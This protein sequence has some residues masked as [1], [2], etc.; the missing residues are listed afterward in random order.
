MCCI[1]K[2]KVSPRPKEE[3]RRDGHRAAAQGTRRQAGGSAWE[4]LTRLRG[5]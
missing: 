2:A 5:K 4:G 1:M 3:K